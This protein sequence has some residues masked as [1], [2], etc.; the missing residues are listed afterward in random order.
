MGS[1]PARGELANVAVWKASL[2]CS[3]ILPAFDF[4]P[5]VS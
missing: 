5:P 4:V 1:H 3:E 2:E